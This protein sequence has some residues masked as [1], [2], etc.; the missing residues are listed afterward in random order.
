MRIMKWDDL[1]I[2]LAVSRAGG[3]AQAGV[4]LAMDHTTVARR[5]GSL[6]AAVGA[7]LVVRSPRGARLT[8]AGAM[9]VAHA[10]QMEAEVLSAAARLGGTDLKPA[11]VVRLATP[12]VFGASFVAPAIKTL[13]DQHPDIQI[14]LIAQSRAVSLTKR[15]ADLAITVSRPPRGRLHVQKL[16]RYRL[17][18]YASR[19]YLAVHGPPAGLDDLRLRPLVWFIDEMIDI[20]ELRYLDQIAAGARTAFRSTSI[21]AQQAA[22][23]AGLGFGVLHCFVADQD[24]GLERVLADSVAIERTYW[25]ASHSDQRN[26][27]RVRTVIEFLQDQ[28]RGARERF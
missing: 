28:V 15:E 25:L 20:P 9:L 21:A 8:E 6:E 2:F 27:P 3:L 19:S 13:H 24:P 14:E 23:V 1:R 7:R 16:T 18:L 5:L 10:E 26:L 12:E 4:H 11:G 22:V 17:G